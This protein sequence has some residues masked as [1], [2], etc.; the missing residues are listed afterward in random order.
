MKEDYDPRGQ[1]ATE[2][3]SPIYKRINTLGSLMDDIHRNIDL[4]ENKL[5]NVMRDIE[6][7]EDDKRPTQIVSCNMEDTLYHL[8]LAAERATIRLH[9]IKSR[10][11]L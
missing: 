6:P 10:I 3:V 11:Q 1:V 7:E 4:V 8:Q 2:T 9:E 5:T